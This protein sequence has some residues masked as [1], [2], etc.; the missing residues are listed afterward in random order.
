M[1]EYSRN[2]AVL[3]KILV[4]GSG[5]REHAICKAL[6]KSKERPTILSFCNTHNPGI[7]D[8][9]VR[10]EMGDLLDLQHL[11]EFAK[12]EKPDFA[13]IGPED[14]IAAGAA[15][16]LAEVGI[17]SIAPTKRLARI[18]SSKSF[19]RK[20]IR[21]Y[22]IAGNPKYQVFFEEEGMLEF[23]KE[24]GEIVVKFDGLAGGKG[25]RVQGDHFSTVEEGLTYAKECLKES[26]KVLLEEKI[27]GQEFSLMFF[28]DGETLVPMPVVQ[29]NKR[30]LV[31]D[32]GPNTGGMGSISN[33]NHSLPF[34]TQ[35][36]IDQA[37]EITTKVIG[38]LQAECEEKYKGIIFGGFI[39]TKDGVRLVEYN[40]RFGDPESLNVF[41]V[42]ASDFVD[43]CKAI[44]E[45]TLKKMEV[46]FY[47]QA[48]VCKYIVPEG[49]PLKPVKDVPILID[50]AKIP[51][52]VELFYGNVDVLEG[53]LLL[54]GSRAVAMVGIA[55]S[56]P[57]AQ[58][59]SEEA[60]RAVEGPVF[61]REDI[62]TGRLLRKRKEMMEQLRKA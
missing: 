18:E 44:L 46:E 15:D 37:K 24:C 13:I 45:G 16:T 61:H 30:A 31:D 1:S 58:Y 43:I 23:A 12:Q 29:D 28:S 6:S 27:V 52:E 60:T 47:E 48:T 5:A 42:L 34:L 39:A 19:T 9:S 55:D 40:A 21:K 53:K 33:A 41:S 4:V 7:A 32:E 59:L 8:V 14:P 36:D 56:L 17:P 57:E 50:N 51:E 10:M 49:Y 22:E 2:F 20:L 25:V 35:K 3:M 11:Q 38:A 54:K 26:G 62:G